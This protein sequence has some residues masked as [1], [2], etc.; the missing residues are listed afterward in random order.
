MPIQSAD[1][2]ELLLSSVEKH[3]QET[4]LAYSGR[5]VMLH[6]LAPDLLP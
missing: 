1:Y 4:C 3:S 6:M 2:R 5:K